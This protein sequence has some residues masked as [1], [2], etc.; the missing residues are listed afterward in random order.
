MT[1]SADVPCVGAGLNP[2]YIV[3][4]GIV[5]TTDVHHINV[6]ADSPMM[7]FAWVK[8]RASPPVDIA[9]RV[10]RPDGKSQLVNWNNP[11]GNYEAYL[12][13]GGLPAGDWT[14]EIINKSPNPATYTL[15]INF[16]DD[17]TF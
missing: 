8:W 6:C 4:P 13:F 14:F 1:T 5:Y 15:R 11:P 3:K 12:D 17:P 7:M 9:M 10:T 2:E 16:N